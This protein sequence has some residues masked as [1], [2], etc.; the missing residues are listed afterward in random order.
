[1][2]I[3]RASRIELEKDSRVL[4]STLREKDSSLMIQMI[5]ILL[6]KLCLLWLI[7]I[8]DGSFPCPCDDERWCQTIQGPPIRTGGEIYGFH[9]S[10]VDSDTLPIGMDM[11]W[12]H[13]TTVAWADKDEIMCLAHQHGARAVIGAPPIENM[14]ALYDSAERREWIQSAL[15]LVL[16]TH[17]DGIVFDYEEPMSIH[18]LEGDV[19]AT[20]IEETSIIF[21]Q[22]NPSLQVTTCVPWSPHDI[23][24][25]A[26]PFERIA[27]A[28][29]A[30]YVMDYDTRSQIF[31]ACIAGANA[32]FSGMINGMEE[33]FNL[34][35]SPSKFI[36]GVPW[37]GY[38][39][40]CLPGTSSDAVYCPI[41]FVPFRG[42]NCSD[43]A[44]T[45]IGYGDAMKKVYETGAV[46]QRDPSTLALYFNTVEPSKRHS[47]EDAVYQYWID[48]PIILIEKYRWARDYGLAGV[49]P[50][51]FRYLDPLN[52]P[53]E[54]KMMW[55]TFD[56]FLFNIGE[57]L[58]PSWEEGTTAELARSMK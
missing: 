7:D 34:G 13:V 48:D 16:Q 45:Q 37:Y 4:L 22:I 43:A 53:E 52:Q 30:L 33:W 41:D 44:G 40:E 50:F 11:N 14:T 56:D 25:R 46:V 29:D 27:K 26:Y 39:Y 15:D 6:T 51:V 20:V 18:S 55:S 21:H 23:D 36:L 9:G 12:T 5:R 19:Y 35:I 28:S 3:L 2:I 54:S 31:D 1:M 17:R 32:P 49:G 42:V 24:G 38:R 47:G 10:W 57:S 58:I 8:V